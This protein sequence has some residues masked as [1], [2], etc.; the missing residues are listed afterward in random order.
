MAKI[1]DSLKIAS[2]AGLSALTAADDGLVDGSFRL[3]QDIGN[4]EGSAWYRYH[5]GS[6]LTA[7]G[8]IIVTGEAGRW[9]K[10]GDRIHVDTADPAAAPPLVGIQWVNTTGPSIYVSIGTASPSDWVPAGGGGGVT[11]V[12]ETSPVGVETPG[13]LNELWIQ[14]VTSGSYPRTTYWLSTG[15]T[16]NDWTAIGGRPVVAEDISPDGSFTA[17]YL[18]QIYFRFAPGEYGG[19]PTLHST[20]VA[21]TLDDSGWALV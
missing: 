10:Q 16:S 7:L 21:L 5:A 13:G 19:P 9:I 6:A 17:E 18:G 14:N 2:L 11:G 12:S 20:Y 15:L 8:K 3:V 1:S 4:N